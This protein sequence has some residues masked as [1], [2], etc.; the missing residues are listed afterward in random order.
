MNLPESESGGGG[1]VAGGG[2]AG[3]GVAGGGGNGGGSDGGGSDD[4]KWQNGDTTCDKA[5]NS[6]TQSEA[7]AWTNR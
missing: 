4:T 1:G 7:T 6:E 3:G 5:E 2:V